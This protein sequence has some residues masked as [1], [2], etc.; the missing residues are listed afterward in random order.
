MKRDGNATAE[1]EPGGNGLWMGAVRW[2][3]QG[4][5]G[6]LVGGGG[7]GGLCVSF[8]TGPWLQEVVEVEMKNEIGGMLSRL[9]TTTTM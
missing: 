4:L 7:G 6:L 3:K 1:T 8:A 9:K 2:R 5:G